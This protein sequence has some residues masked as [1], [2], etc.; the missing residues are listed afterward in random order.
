MD[1]PV[2]HKTACIL[3]YVNCG[4]EV[5]TVGR[6]I[7]R[8]RGDRDNP[9][10]KGYICQKAGRIPFCRRDERLQSLSALAHQSESHALTVPW[11]LAAPTQAT[12]GGDLK[13]I[14][15]H[16]SWCASRKLDCEREKLFAA[17]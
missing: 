3:C 17:V 14:G 13:K 2:A 16:T 5:E 1:A 15:W 10:S 12:P 11:H 6:E 9:K 8:V 7:T 4:I